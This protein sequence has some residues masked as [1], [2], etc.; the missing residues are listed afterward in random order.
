MLGQDNYRFSYA[1]VH[2]EVV[3][4]GGGLLHKHSLFAKMQMPKGTYLTSTYLFD[5][6]AIAVL[7]Y[8]GTIALLDSEGVILRQIQLLSEMS[9]N[10]FRGRNDGHQWSLTSRRNS[11]A[12]ECNHGPFDTVDEMLD[13]VGQVVALEESLIADGDGGEAFIIAGDLALV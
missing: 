12:A 13:T 7:D 10:I 1:I 5:G 11:W 8:D 3:K 6:V 9:I 2:G 4:S